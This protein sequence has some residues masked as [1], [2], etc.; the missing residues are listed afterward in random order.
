MSKSF[1][2]AV[3]IDDDPDIVFAARLALRGLFVEVLGFTV[4]ERA[5]AL[6]R[7][8]SPDVILLDADCAREVPGDARGAN[9]LALILDH[10]PDAVVVL[11]TAHPWIGIAAETMRCG[12]TDFVVKPWSNDRLQATAATAARLRVSRR[13]TAAEK[14]RVAM[15]RRPIARR[16]ASS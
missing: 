16:A 12:A 4:A 10:D 13:A 8:R 7:E 6:I 14:A 3:V 5:F 11:T 1:D 9:R 2:L 15:L